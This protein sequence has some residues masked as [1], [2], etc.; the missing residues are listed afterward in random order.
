MKNARPSEIFETLKSNPM[1]AKCWNRCT[2]AELD[3]CRAFLKTHES[4]GLNVLN[5]EINQWYMDQPNKPRHYADM[6]ALLVACAPRSIERR[7]R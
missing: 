7:K 3:E 1:L 6:W 4:R 2:K 5:R